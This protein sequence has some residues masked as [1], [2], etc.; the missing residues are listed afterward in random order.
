MGA[1]SRCAVAANHAR[2]LSQAVLLAE[3]LINE[4]RLQPQAAFETR[5]GEQLPYQWDISINPTPI[6]NLA[7]VQV[8]VHWLEQHRPQQFELLSLVTMALDEN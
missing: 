3:K 8:Q 5:Q 1:M 6:E 7:T 4:V 2:H